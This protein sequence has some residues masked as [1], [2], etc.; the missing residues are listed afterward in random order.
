MELLVNVNAMS[1]IVDQLL[2]VFSITFIYIEEKNISRV[3]PYINRLY[4]KSI[5]FG[6]KT[7]TYF[8]SFTE[9][10]RLIKM[11]INELSISSHR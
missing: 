8:K 9:F 1:I 6:C 10:V 5:L 11:C 3:N 4:I 2:L 7:E